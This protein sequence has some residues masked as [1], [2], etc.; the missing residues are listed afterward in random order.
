MESFNNLTHHKITEEL[1]NKMRSIPLVG[2]E[3]IKPYENS[4]F[5]LLD[6]PINSIRPT[7]LY[8]LE[9]NI[10]FLNSLLNEVPLF[11][12][13]GIT[14]TSFGIVAPP[15]IEVHD[16]MFILL[17]GQNRLWLA[18]NKGVESLHC[19]VIT[20][21][22][23]PMPV[24][25]VEWD[26]VGVFKDKPAVSRRYNPLLENP[27]AFYRNLG[28]LGSEGQR[29]IKVC[30]DFDDVISLKEDYL[31]YYA[32]EYNNGVVDSEIKIRAYND[33]EEQIE[34]LKLSV[35]AVN[36][37]KAMQ[38]QHYDITIVTSRGINEG[39]IAEEILRMHGIY[40]PVIKVGPDSKY[41]HYSNAEIVIDNKLSHLE[42]V[43]ANPVRKNTLYLFG[44]E[45]QN[46][47]I[48]TVSSW[49]ELAVILGIELVG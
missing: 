38:K 2:D 35:S 41:P 36:T 47:D 6:I 40:L 49:E 42:E 10:D 48:K 37:I 17:D 13:S 44:G 24:L 19:I 11:E 43:T 14:K 29:K 46:G 39:T 26:E 8:V 21:V 9:R 30:I 12:L 22:N 34:H 33:K 32:D 31:K 4:E 5:F 18:R 16:G 25:P 45:H 3:T 23:T 7:A 20:N 28:I 15:I 27:S 1:K